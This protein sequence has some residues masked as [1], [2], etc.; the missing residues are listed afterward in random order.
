MPNEEQIFQRIDRLVETFG[1]PKR[2]LMKHIRDGM[3][4][5]LSA[6]GGFCYDVQKLRQVIDAA[7]EKK[8][9]DE[10]T[11]EP[12]YPLLLGFRVA[13]TDQLITVWCPHC[14]E[15]H[16]HGLSAVDWKNRQGVHRASHCSNPESPFN[17]T[18]YKIGLFNY[19]E[20]R[21]IVTNIKEHLGPQTRRG[22]GRRSGARA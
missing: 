10:V 7:A 1:L 9:V 22:R 20:M 4:P 11:G 2:C 14:Q 21:R 13:G 3:V 6:L 17:R 16:D 5:R 18:G 12:G 15:F 8:G 19:H